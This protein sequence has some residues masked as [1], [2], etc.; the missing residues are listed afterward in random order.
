MRMYCWYYCYCCLRY[1][2]RV[3]EGSPVSNLEDGDGTQSEQAA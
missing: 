1:C 3:E 2:C